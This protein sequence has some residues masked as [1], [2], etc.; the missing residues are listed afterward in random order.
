VDDH[1]QELG[2]EPGEYL[3]ETIE[4]QPDLAR[5][6]LTSL[7]E[8]ARR[9]RGARRVFVV[10]TGTSFHGALVGQ[11][12][13][14]SV[15]LDAWAVPAFEFACY[16]PRLTGEEGLVLVS[17]RGTK[18]FSQAAL[19]RARR[20]TERWVV[21]TGE[22]SPI[23]G[24]E[25]VWTTSQERSPV[26]TASHL[27]AMIRLAQVAVSLATEPPDW[28]RQLDRLPA[29]IEAVVGLREQMATVAARL[30]LDRTVHFVG[31][32]PARA[33]ALEGAL[34]IREAAYV[35]AEGHDVEG[36]LHGP[37]ISLQPGQSAV[38]IAQPGPSLERTQELAS[39]LDD[40]GLTT[41]AVGPAA[42]AVTAA[43]QIKTPLFDESLAPVTNVVP[44]Q[45]L[46]YEASRRRGVDADSFRRDVAAYAAAQGRFTL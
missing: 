9:L 15:G 17:H 44:L 38:L 27:G 32:G 35:A 5:R 2:K 22:G 40:I 41:V 45:W 8:A 11:Y 39:A 28:A 30:D 20:M 7:P 6:L 37:L 42:A 31:G 25:V 43:I 19:G 3:R 26:H 23:E 16:P 18:R 12:L 10:G 4:S 14:R 29:A 46:A 34:K 21:I 24:P 13:L 36:I 1:G 33:T